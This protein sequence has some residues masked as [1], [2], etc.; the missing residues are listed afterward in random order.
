MLDD[1]EY[2]HIKADYRD[3]FNSKS[4]F[5]QIVAFN[6]PDIIRKI[7][8]TYRVQFLKDVALARI[9][10]E[11]SFSSLS[12]I[13]FFNQSEIVAYIQ[14]DQSFQIQIF[15]ILS[16]ENLSAQKRKDVIM[17]LHELSVTVKGLHV[18]SKVEFFRSLASH[19]LFAIFEYTIGDEDIDIRIAIISLLTNIL[20]NEAAL[21]RSFCLAQAKQNQKTLM[22]TV[23]ERL[24]GETDSGLRSQLSEII[25]MMID[26]TRVDAVSEGIVHHTSDA[27]DFLNLFYENYVSQ[28]AHPIMSLNEK[29]IFLKN[30]MNYNHNID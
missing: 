25:R 28:L 5:K 27:E 11:N 30:G 18:Q 20:E 26:T 16:E 9:L 1:K 14:K 2:P 21:V 13:A 24:V 6:N 3:H 15:A 8:N 19:G 4:K 12:S 10:D 23:I 22:E 7:I 17:F 29:M